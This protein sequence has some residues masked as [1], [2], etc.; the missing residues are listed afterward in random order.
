MS[1]C[2]FVADFM[3]VQKHRAVSPCAASGVLGVCVCVCGLSV[4]C[5]AVCE[6]GVI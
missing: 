1:G 2:P 6:S 4:E 5:E 3:R